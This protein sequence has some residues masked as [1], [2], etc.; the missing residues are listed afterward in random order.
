MVCTFISHPYPACPSNNELCWPP[1]VAFVAQPLVLCET[2][3]ATSASSPGTRHVGQRVSHFKRWSAVGQGHGLLV[4]FIKICK[5]L[6]FSFFNQ[7]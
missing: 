7:L 6:P 1:K 3:S 2:P 4:Y 5:I